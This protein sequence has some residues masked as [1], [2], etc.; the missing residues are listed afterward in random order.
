M[1]RIK[2][3]NKK[4]GLNLDKNLKTKE[5]KRKERRTVADN[6]ITLLNNFY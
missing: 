1:L 2:M 5:L 4:E 6:P 3:K